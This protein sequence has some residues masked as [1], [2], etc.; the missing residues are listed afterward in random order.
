MGFKIDISPFY[1]FAK[2]E[3]SIDEAVHKLVPD[4]PV[5]W[6]DVLLGFIIGILIVL[7]II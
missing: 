2:G 7:V 5:V 1:K 4:K 3:I 6:L